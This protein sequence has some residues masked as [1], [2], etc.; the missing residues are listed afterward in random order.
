MSNETRTTEA[1]ESWRRLYAK[2]HGKRVVLEGVLEWMTSTNRWCYG[3]KVFDR[4]RD[5]TIKNLKVLGKTKKWQAVV[6][7]KAAFERGDVDEALEEWYDK[8][9]KIWKE[10]K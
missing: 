3:A 4:V 8:W 1:E 5:F 10:N 7:P 6:F 9:E 2:E